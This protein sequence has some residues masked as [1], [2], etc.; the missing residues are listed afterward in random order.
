VVRG[1]EHAA[2]ARVRAGQL[3]DAVDRTCS[4]FRDDSDLVRANRAAGRRVRVD[5]LLAR[6]VE[7][8]LGAAEAS[9]GLVDP[10]LGATIAALGYDRDL[11]EVRAGTGR[12]IG[13]KPGAGPAERPGP[14]DLPT[15]SPR[16]AW[17]EV[18]VDP[19][20]GLLVP[21]GVALD[22]G[23]TGKAFAADLV[24][25]T[26]TAELGVACVVSLGGDVAV[27][28]PARDG[29]APAWPVEV[30]ETPRDPDGETVELEAGGLAT[31]TTVRR[32]WRAGGR[33][34]HHL[35]DPR[36]GAPVEPT[37]RTA[38]VAAATCV[39]ANTASTAAV[40]LGAAAADWLGALGLPARLVSAD[41]V[42]V[43]C[44]GWPAR[45][46]QEEEA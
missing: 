32:R 3:L 29:A 33:E 11:A 39:E 16:P 38:S 41:G 45:D 17:R 21:A 30:G 24:A 35:L 8:A 43:H 9:D 7:A 46:E 12:A 44:G 14:A 23:A 5:P 40:V 20:G 19:D 28:G 22:L 31:S 2:A 6:A 34:L 25:A 27:G 18:E 10:T 15:P 1:P 13:E 4:R 36:T 37:W 42:V 26:L